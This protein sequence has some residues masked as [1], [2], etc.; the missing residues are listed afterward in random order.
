MGLELPA[1]PSSLAAYVPALRWEKTVYISGQLPLLDGTLMC[2]GRLGAEVDEDQGIKAARRCTLNALAVLK[3]EIG[4]LA[5]VVQVLKLT[6][7]VAS[8]QAFSKQPTVANGASELL[9][10]V[11]EVRGRHARSAVGVASLPL[12][13]SVELELIVAVD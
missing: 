9:E 6:V 11:F 7:F 13:A 8:D 5:H 12:G 4:D 1:P 2:T 3:A 10:E